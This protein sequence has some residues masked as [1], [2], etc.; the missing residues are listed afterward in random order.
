MPLPPVFLFGAA[1][2]YGTRL[3]ATFWDYIL[4]PALVASKGGTSR[5]RAII[6]LHF[7]TALQGVGLPIWGDIGSF[8]RDN[9]YDDPVDVAA[10]GLAIFGAAQFGSGPFTRIAVAGGIRSFAASLQVLGTMV[11][12][13]LRG[14]RE[15][16][17]GNTARILNESDASRRAFEKTGQQLMD[18]VANLAAF[19]AN[20]NPANLGTGLFAMAAGIA[21]VGATLWGFFEGIAG[22]ENPVSLD[23]NPFIVPESQQFD[24]ATLDPGLR[25][26]LPTPRGPPGV[27]LPPPPVTE[28]DI[29]EGLEDLEGGRIQLPRFGL[30]RG[31][32]ISGRDPTTRAIVQGL[33]I[34]GQT[35]GAANK[36]LRAFGIG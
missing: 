19:V 1:M 9:A 3:A 2:T 33:D 27:E 15:E 23:R 31:V 10:D 14:D 26:A 22:T 8:L 17:I 20:P 12:G 35:A 11:G 25:A 5:E 29:T 36:L 4:I 6:D 16:L 28:E 18:G 32:I 30:S 7:R 21:G 24:P 34:A 13:L